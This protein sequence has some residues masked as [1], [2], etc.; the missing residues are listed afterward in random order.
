MKIRQ[1]FDLTD[2]QFGRWKVLDRAEPPAHI[3]SSLTQAYWLCECECGNQSI[4][5]ACNLRNGRS[6]SCGC[7]TLANK[8][9]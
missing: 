4:V 5:R 2:C 8:S 7:G 3:T 6:K 9:P 1:C